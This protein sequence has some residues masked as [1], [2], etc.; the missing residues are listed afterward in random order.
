MSWLIWRK[1][2]PLYLTHQRSLKKEITADRWREDQRSRGDGYGHQSTGCFFLP[3]S[4]SL[5]SRKAKSQNF[6]A[7]ME[8]KGPKSSHLFM[9][10]GPG[11]GALWKKR[12]RKIYC[13]FLSFSVLSQT[14][15]PEL[16][17]HEGSSSHFFFLFFPLSIMVLH[18][19][20][21]TNANMDRPHHPCPCRVWFHWSVF[22]KCPPRAGE[23]RKQHWSRGMHVAQVALPAVKGVRSVYV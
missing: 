18:P 5:D 23:A 7:G 19:A 8:G 6:S 17:S 16:Y 1:H 22:F 15:V 10:R 2:A 11:K 13:F 21:L 3:L 20:A 12:V 9:T 14:N 4:P